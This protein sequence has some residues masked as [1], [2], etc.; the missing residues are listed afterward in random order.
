MVKKLVRIAVIFILMVAVIVGAAG[1]LFHA[2]FTP[3]RLQKI[4]V[5]ESRGM[6]NRETRV[7]SISFGFLSGLEM[8]NLAVSERPDFR[9]GTF[10]TLERLS[11]RFRPQALLNNTLSISE[12]EIVS[13]KVVM[14]RAADGTLNTADLSSMRHHAPAYAPMALLISRCRV[15]NGTFEFVDGRARG[16][17]TALRD[18]RLDADGISMF[19]PFN[20]SLS[21]NIVVGRNTAALA[22]QFSADVARKRIQIRECSLGEKSSVVHISG[23]VDNFDDPAACAFDLQV[24]GGRAALDTL[25]ALIAPGQNIRLFG[26]Q[27]IRLNITGTPGKVVVDFSPMV[28]ERAGISF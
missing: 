6:L 16:L 14:T 5:N 18:V 7:A 28:G 13:P 26:L 24:E 8:K 10:A 12:M 1:I 11:V 25:L 27:K 9:A 21:G 3:A 20:A 15:T 4:F 17:T 23:I 22:A 19:E 2:V